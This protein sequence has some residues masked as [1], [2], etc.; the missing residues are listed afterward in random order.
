MLTI[1]KEK[2]YASLV[3][4]GGSMDTNNIK[5][6]PAWPVIVILMAL[7]MLFS[8]FAVYRS[9]APVDGIGMPIGLRV[10]PAK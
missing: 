4:E 8:G 3:K 9:I 7:F 2:K 5:K 1:T 6:D 10:P